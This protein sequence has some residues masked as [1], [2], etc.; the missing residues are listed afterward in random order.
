M[1]IATSFPGPA[2]LSITCST[3]KRVLQATESWVGPGNEAMGIVQ[4]NFYTITLLNYV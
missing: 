3:E 2:Q 4:D 1:G